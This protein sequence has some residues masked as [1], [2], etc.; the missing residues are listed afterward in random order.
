[1]RPR[2]KKLAVLG[3]DQR[4]KWLAL[5]L[6]DE[7]I[8][9]QTHLVPDCSD[10]PL[11]RALTE[12][13]GVV[14]PVPAFSPEGLLTVQRGGPVTMEEILAVLRPGTRIF[15][16]RLHDTAGKMRQAGLEPIDYMT[17]EPVAVAN[18]VPT[19]E[20]AIQI[21]MEQMPSTLQNS[22]CLVI[23]WG[24]IGKL[25]AG[26][27]KALG[28]KVTVSVRRAED[29]AMVQALGMQSDLT[30]VYANGLPYA[31]IVNTVPAMVLG[32]KA[33]ERTVPDVCIIDLASAP[34]GVDFPA[35]E[36]LKR[37]AVLALGLPGKM[38]PKTAGCI[39]K[40][41]ILTYL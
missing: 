37:T 23:G 5:A 18:A 6:M 34:G 19:A 2:T 36:R 13:D 22:Q 39:L 21:A 40:D 7:G 24:R 27:L 14:L 30:G 26:K 31:L 38:A 9:V 35:A 11:A 29:A 3:G 12:V 20:G 25:L 15:G 17:L 41:A 33:L 28:A 8:L 32:Q 4:Q 10:T 1:M 16:G